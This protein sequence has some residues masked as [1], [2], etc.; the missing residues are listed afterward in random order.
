MTKYTFVITGEVAAQSEDKAKSKLRNMIDDYDI[1]AK[2]D[3]LGE[4]VKLK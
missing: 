3:M 2:V 4:F 1:D